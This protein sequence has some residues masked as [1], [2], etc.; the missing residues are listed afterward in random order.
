MV[1]VVEC[2]LVLEFVQE[3][4][5]RR[6]R[7]IPQGLHFLPQRLPGRAEL[8]FQERSYRASLPG[9]LFDFQMKLF[10]SCASENK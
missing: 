9:C 2:F 7:F 3:T 5:Q 8:W 4:E 10:M 6:I 1:G